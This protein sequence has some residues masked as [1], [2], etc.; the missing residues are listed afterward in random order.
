MKK[1]L[2][3]LCAMVMALLPVVGMA[4]AEVSA[5][6]EEPNPNWKA[7]ETIL[8]DTVVDHPLDTWK[9]EELGGFIIAV[10]SIELAAQEK[11]EGGGLVANN[12]YIGYS[13]NCLYLVVQRNSDR[14]YIIEFDRQYSMCMYQERSCDETTDYEK[15]CEEFCGE[16]YWKVEPKAVQAAFYKLMN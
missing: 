3:V 14:M 9:D 7:F 15:I 6:A 1:L 12:C 13:E 10:T 11:A 16:N 5:V 2:C 4:A 8:L